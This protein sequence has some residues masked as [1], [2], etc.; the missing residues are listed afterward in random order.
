[1]LVVSWAESSLEFF[2]LTFAIATRIGVSIALLTAVPRLT[3]VLLYCS[4]VVLLYCLKSNRR[5]KEE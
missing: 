1:M 3:W 2:Y 5:T 4:Y